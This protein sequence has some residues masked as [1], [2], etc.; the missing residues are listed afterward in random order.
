MSAKH[1]RSKSYGYE[2]E[3][4]AE[5]RLRAVFPNMR[6]MGS[7]A[8]RKDAADLVQE[9]ASDSDPY[10]FV[11]TR[12]KRKPL[13]ITM[14][15]DDFIYLCDDKTARDARAFVQVKGREKTWIGGLYEALVKA[16]E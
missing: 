15:M 10:R 1:R 7:V 9:N 4:A 12:D 16:T 14:S 11:V 6:R 3:K 13:L 2:V 8:Y 5:A